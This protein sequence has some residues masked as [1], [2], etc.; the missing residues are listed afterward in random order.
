MVSPYRQLEIREE[1][2]T[3]KK[4][5]SKREEK[6]EAPIQRLYLP[7]LKTSAKITAP[8]IHSEAACTSHI[9]KDSALAQFCNTSVNGS[10]NVASI[11]SCYW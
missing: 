6:R 5:R 2:D 9:A 3:G 1:E 7:L 10:R 4:R 11:L 8:Q